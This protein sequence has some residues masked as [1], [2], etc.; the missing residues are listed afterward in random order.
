MADERLL[1][2]IDAYASAVLSWV[3]PDGYPASA[4]CLVR[5]EPGSERITLT[6]VPA[7][8]VDR[9]GPACLLFHRHDERLEGLH[10]LLLRGALVDGFP[11]ED[12]S[13]PAFLV[14]GVVTANGRDDTDA[15]PH[16]SAPLHMLRFYL[17]GRRQAKAYLLKRGEP[18]PPIPFPEIDR[19]VREVLRAA[20]DTPGP[21]DA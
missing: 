4:R 16:A 7:V 11:G 10:Q 18:W 9:R 13:S 2:L 6:S 17:V 1:A 19:K 15:M 12:A 14:T 5:R 21:G 8:A 3:E 20:A